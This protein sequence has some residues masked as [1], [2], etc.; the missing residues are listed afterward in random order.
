MLLSYRAVLNRRPE[1]KKLPI[2]DSN[3]ANEFRVV[4]GQ[5]CVQAS[6]TAS[7]I[8]QELT[9]DY[10][11]QQC[12]TIKRVA[13]KLNEREKTKQTTIKKVMVLLKYNIAD[14]SF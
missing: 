12:L 14:V 7:T 9:Q 11:D 10:L 2:I 8:P 1:P 3:L 6:R 5:L 4:L 13:D